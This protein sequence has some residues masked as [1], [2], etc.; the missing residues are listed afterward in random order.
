MKQID[1]CPQLFQAEPAQACFQRYV[2]RNRGEL[3]HQW[4]K[5]RSTDF[6]RY[7]LSVYTGNT[8]AEFQ[9]VKAE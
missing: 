3:E 4:Q 1:L 7:C 9:I 8:P 5:T 6:W 2:E